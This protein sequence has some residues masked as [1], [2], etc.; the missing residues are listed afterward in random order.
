[1]SHEHGG[2]E[3]SIR[4]EA[5]EA[6]ADEIEKAERRYRAATGIGRQAVEELVSE[7][8]EEDRDKLLPPLYD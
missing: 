6:L 5:A 3:A 4:R 1:M 2:G 8:I 7:T